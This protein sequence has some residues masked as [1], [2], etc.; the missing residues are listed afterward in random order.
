MSAKTISFVKGKGSLRHNNR[1]FIAD[2][3]DEKRIGFNK[4]YIKQSLEEAY[5]ICFGDALREYNEKQTR[6]DRKKD[7]YI[8]EIKNSKNREKVFYENVVQIGTMQDTGV[9]NGEGLVSYDARKA[10]EI[11]DEY[12]KTFQERNP[13]LYVFNCVLHMDEATPHLHIDYIPV[14][15][16]YK[17]GMNTRNS[18]TK[19]LQE[20]GFDKAISN[21]LNETVAWQKREREHIQSLCEEKNIEIEIK[22]EKRENLSLPEYRE[23]M[24]EVDRLQEEA[25]NLS[26]DNSVLIEQNESLEQMVSENQQALEVVNK[27]LKK[28]EARL[29]EYTL[30][31][32]LVKSV[33]KAIDSDLKSIKSEVT[34]SRPFI[35]SEDQ[36]KMSMPLWNKI[37]KVCKKAFKDNAVV[38]KLNK[39]MEKLQEKLDD[40]NERLSKYADFIKKNDLESEYR[41]YE[42]ELEEPAFNSLIARKKAQ[43]EQDNEER[44]RENETYKI[45]RER[46]RNDDVL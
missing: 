33:K 2:N 15:H 19:A 24:K 39:T 34:I 11:L 42:R 31:A 17:K 25:I 23:A 41:A 43:A 9:L 14:A 26:V 30:E 36:V 28:Q 46:K 6:N 20:M 7:N 40:A 32:D 35:G 37:C 3:V 22:G 16:G 29:K 38:A 1:D 27:D 4:T 8:I 12:A 18:L 21:R 10:A 45:A 13:N 5:E 44:R